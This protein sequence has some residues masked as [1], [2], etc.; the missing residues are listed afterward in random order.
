MLPLLEGSPPSHSNIGDIPGNYE[1]ISTKF[2]E[3]SLLTSVL[4]IGGKANMTSGGREG[5]EVKRQFVIQSP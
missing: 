1:R 3:I 2:L 5:G 4:H